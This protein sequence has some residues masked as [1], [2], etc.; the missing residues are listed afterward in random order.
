MGVKQ[1]THTCLPLRSLVGLL[2]LF[3]NI[4][5]MF[6]MLLSLPLRMVDVLTIPVVEAIIVVTAENMPFMLWLAGNGWAWTS[7]CLF[8]IA[9]FSHAF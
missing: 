6:L 9:F 4:P 1:I 8:V 2:N 7:F 3:L 5:G